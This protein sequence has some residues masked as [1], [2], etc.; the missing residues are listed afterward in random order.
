MKQIGKTVVFL[1]IAALAVTFVRA[2]ESSV[3]KG[4]GGPGNGAGK[5]IILPSI[6]NEDGSI[7]IDNIEAF[8]S[9]FDVDSDGLISVEEQKAMSSMIRPQKSPKKVAKKHPKGPGFHKCGKCPHPGM[10]DC[11]CGKKCDCPRC[12]CAKCDCPR[13]DCPKCAKKRPG[14]RRFGKGPRPGMKDCPWG[15]KCDSAQGPCPTGPA[16]AGSEVPADAQ[17]ASE[18]EEPSNA[19][20]TDE[21][22]PNEQSAPGE[23]APAEGNDT[24]D[25]S[26]ASEEGAAGDTGDNAE[27]TN[28]EGSPD[29]GGASEQE[30]GGEQ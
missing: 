23:E 15:K 24:A 12:D 27:A 1:M 4:P 5:V 20:A 19:P 25:E 7:V 9:S 26:T 22:A 8:L 13:C 28:N 30:P 14:F 18:N 11:H 21:A 3:P 16:P 17:N 10:R 29:E 2:D 6:T